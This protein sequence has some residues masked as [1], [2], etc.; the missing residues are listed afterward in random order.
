[1][2]FYA[3]YVIFASLLYHYSTNFVT[4]QHPKGGIERFQRLDENDHFLEK[5]AILHTLNS[6]D[7]FYSFPY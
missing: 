6:F 3:L 7:F 2:H 4:E 1:M 5:N